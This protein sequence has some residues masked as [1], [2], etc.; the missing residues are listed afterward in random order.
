MTSDKKNIVFIVDID[1]DGDGRWASSR[2]APYEYSIKSWS[3]WCKKNNCE[4]FVLNDLLMSH[5][6]MGIC[7]QRYYLFDILEANNIQYD[8]VLSVDADTIVHPDCPNFF[9]MTDRKLT[10]VHNDGSYDWVIRSIENYSKFFFNGHIMP[11]WKY[12]DCGFVIVNESHKSFFKHITDF[13]HANAKQ[14]QLAEKTWHTGTDQTPVNFLIDECNIDLK[15]L[16]YEF[17][18]IDLNRKELLT[19]NLPFTD[20]G[21]IYQYNGIPNNK[22]DELTLYWMKKTYEAL[23]EN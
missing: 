4:L 15:L 10:G 8:Q 22:N 2:R 16:S 19:D 13:Y 20:I 5:Q 6:E 7:W 12:I 18:M 21:Y 11:F 14:L 17:N 9:E 23:Y 3:N 1:L